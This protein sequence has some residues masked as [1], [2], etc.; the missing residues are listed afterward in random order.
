MNVMSSED[1]T[2]EDGSPMLIDQQYLSTSLDELGKWSEKS[3]PDISGQAKFLT[4]H[5]CKDITMTCSE[6]I[7]KSKFLSKI[8][9]R[10]NTTLLIFGIK[11]Y[12][13]FSFESDGHTCT[14]RPGD[15]WLINI[16]NDSL[17]RI[18]Q[19]DQYNEMTVL[20]YSTHRITQ[21]FGRGADESKFISN[22]ILRLGR[23]ES[24]DYWLQDLLNNPLASASDRLLA[25]AQT[26]VLMSRWIGPA[27]PSLNR[28]IE[29]V[30][31]DEKEKMRTVMELLIKDLANTPSLQKMSGCVNMSHTRLNRIFKKVYG[32]TVF[33][34]L[35]EYRLERARSYLKDD[36]RSV[37]AI[38]F[39]CGF[40]SASHFSQSFKKQYKCS[41][42]E[43]RQYHQH[44]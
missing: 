36:N 2:A 31:Q 21:A 30:T 14:V 23:E 44:V 32:A 27:V 19:A 15:V 37:T 8:H 35:R 12:S 26:L 33:N 17:C 1:H 25:E 5:I 34:W 43:Y 16:S 38:A 20:R 41:P 24:I 18:T 6:C 39:L 40:S 9:Y 42:V 22:S 4:A 11:G 10:T 29:G 7:F 13:T 28:Y 3:L